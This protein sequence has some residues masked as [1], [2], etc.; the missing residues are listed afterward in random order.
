MITYILEIF[1]SMIESFLR[2]FEVY[3][4]IIIIRLFIQLHILTYL[5]KW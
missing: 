2:D 1:K 5:I 4:K 3:I